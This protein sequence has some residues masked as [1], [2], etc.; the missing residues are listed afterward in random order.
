MCYISLENNEMLIFIVLKINIFKYMKKSHLY[1]VDL[2]RVT[3]I[4]RRQDDVAIKSPDF[5][6]PKI[7]DG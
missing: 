7:S 3:F 6:L 5:K 4:K 1:F 2:R